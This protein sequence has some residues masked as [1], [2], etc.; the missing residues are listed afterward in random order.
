MLQSAA[1]AEMPSTVASGTD[2]VAMPDRNYNGDP[3]DMTY[4]HISERPNQSNGETIGGSSDDDRGE[5]TTVCLPSDLRDVHLTRKE[6]KIVMAA[7]RNPR[8]GID[9]LSRQTDIRPRRVRRVLQEIWPSH[10][11]VEPDTLDISVEDWEDRV[12]GTDI[13]ADPRD[14]TQKER[15][16]LDYAMANRDAYQ[17]VIGEAT[18]RPRTTVT[19]TLNRH[20]PS[21]GSVGRVHTSEVSTESLIKDI[22]DIAET[23]GHPPRAWEYNRD[24]EFSDTTARRRLGKWDTALK[25]AGLNPRHKPVASPPSPPTPFGIGI[26]DGQMTLEDFI[27]GSGA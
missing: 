26:P 3:I 4:Q 23:L 10:D 20:F 13:P 2:F 1:V 5:E 16:V 24:G 15:D 27:D 14:L 11:A 21:H 18:G 6:R 9:S 8:A 22:Q 17:Y 12:A 7:G 19:S 25:R